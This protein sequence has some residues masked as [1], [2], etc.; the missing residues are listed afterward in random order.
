MEGEL[1]RRVFDEEFKLGAIRLIKEE[2]RRVS[3]VARDLGIAQG[4]LH[5]WIRQQK[6]NGE[7]AF[8]GKGHLRPEEEQ[9]K[10]LEKELRDVK[11]ERDILKKAIAIFSRVKP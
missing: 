2:G 10:K 6:E 1:K 9:M 5:K 7:S 8:P 3:D 4:L 11:E